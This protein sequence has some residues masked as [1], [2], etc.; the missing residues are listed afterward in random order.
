MEELALAQA[1][2]PVKKWF[3]YNLLNSIHINFTLE[4]EQDGHL[5]VATDLSLQTFT[6]NLRKL[7]NT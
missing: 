2:T 4:Q 1:T 5:H 6:V 7:T 3:T